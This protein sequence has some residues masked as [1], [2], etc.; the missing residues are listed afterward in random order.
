MALKENLREERAKDTVG[1]PKF[2]SKSF[3][4]KGGEAGSSKKEGKGGSTDGIGG[5]FRSE[6][7]K[8]EPVFHEAAYRDGKDKNYE[9]KP[10]TGTP[11]QEASYQNRDRQGSGLSNEPKYQQK[12]PSYP[13]S[14]PK[15]KE[16]AQEDD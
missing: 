2:P 11:R 14:G 1:T 3:G 6:D 15:T 12:L 5:G 16:G 8:D 9:K 10:E 7:V 13:T 4:R